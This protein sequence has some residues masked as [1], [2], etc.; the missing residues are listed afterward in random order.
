[1][2][3]LKELKGSGDYT[4]GPGFTRGKC[5]AVAFDCASHEQAEA[6][7]FAVFPPEINGAP[8]GSVDVA[9]Q[10]GGIYF[11][12]LDYERGVQTPND[13]AAG[14]PPAETRPP[15]PGGGKQNTD[16]LTRD[17]TFSTGGGTRRRM[18]S[19]ETRHKL[20]ANPAEPAPDFGGL[21]GVTKDG[22]VEGCEVIAPAADFTISKRFASLTVG[23]FRNMLDLIACTNEDDW[24]GM[25]AGEV[26]FK[27]CDGNYKDGDDYPWSVTGKFGYARNYVRGESEA[28]DD[29][30][31][32]GGIQIPDIGGWEHLWISYQTKIETITVAGAPLKVSVDYPRWAYV[33]VVYLAGN[34]SDLGLD[35]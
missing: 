20:T 26:L 19:I 16:P 5:L 2:A 30:L 9:D 33:E 21:I 24:L 27:G 31:T 10:G 13:P 29:M 34:L 1:M 7:A 3:W 15:S 8:L 12:T 6:L 11:I 4:R 22:K 25:Y 14:E 28:I 32:V 23:W 18:T 35:V 17:M